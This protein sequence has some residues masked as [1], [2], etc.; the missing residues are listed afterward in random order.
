[1]AGGTSKALGTNQQ[2][3]EIGTLHQVNITRLFLSMAKW[4]GVSPGNT[5]GIMWVYITMINHPPVIT[6][7]SWCKPFPHGWFI[8]YC[9][10]IFHPH[11]PTWLVIV[12]AACTKNQGP[13]S[14][15][16]RAIRKLEFLTAKPTTSNLAIETQIHSS[17]DSLSVL[18][19]VA[20]CQHNRQVLPPPKEA[21]VPRSFFC[22]VPHCWVGGARI[23]LP[24]LWRGTPSRRIKLLLFKETI[25]R[26][27]SFSTRQKKRIGSSFPQTFAQTRICLQ[28]RP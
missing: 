26:S 10:T 1:M 20:T 12:K 27:P 23:Y 2:P 6:I 9:Y 19:V 11:Y 18:G 4:S 8:Y 13:Q 28:R 25:F 22:F 24:G 15:S 17:Q 21:F 16:A 5:A 3:S 14:D 7:D